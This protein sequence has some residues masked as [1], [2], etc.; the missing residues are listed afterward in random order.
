MESNLNISTVE[1]VDPTKTKKRAHQISKGLVCGVFCG[2]VIGCLLYFLVINRANEKHRE[3][4]N[5]AMPFAKG[6]IDEK[7]REELMEKDGEEFPFLKGIVYCVYVK[8]FLNLKS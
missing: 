8:L 4:G 6:V 2:V 7:H 1:L 3:E 5:K